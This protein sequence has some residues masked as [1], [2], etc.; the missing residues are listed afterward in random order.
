MSTNG[1]VSED[2]QKL[3]DYGIDTKVAH[4]LDSIYQA[5][6]LAHS[7]LDERALDAL[8]EFTVEKGM[9]LGVSA[10]LYG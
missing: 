1:D 3:V 8:K 4:E 9:K 10:Y 6:I 5:G 2:H 7:D